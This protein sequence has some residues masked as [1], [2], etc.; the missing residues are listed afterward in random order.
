V[1]I[2]CDS[3][4]IKAKHLP[5]EIKDKHN[6]SS[7]YD[8]PTTWDEFKKYKQQVKDEVVIRIEEQFLIDALKSTGGNVSKAAKITGMQRTNF[9]SLL[10]KYNLNSRD[11]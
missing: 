7:K 3:E 2:L 1:A 6:D 5:K 4:V 11:Y 10:K 8:F 9:H